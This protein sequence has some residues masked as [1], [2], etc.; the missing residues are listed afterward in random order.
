MNIVLISIFVLVMLGGIVSAIH[1]SDLRHHAIEASFASLRIPL[2]DGWVGTDQL[3]V[4]R[5]VRGVRSQRCEGLRNV[6]SETAAYWYLV[7]PGPSY[8]LAMQSDTLR[9]GE[10]TVDWQ[11]TPLTEER[12]RRALFDDRKATALAFASTPKPDAA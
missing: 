5:R 9:G 12:M 3:R 4:V 7:G 10:V 1:F 2:A 11:V 8:F 6:Y